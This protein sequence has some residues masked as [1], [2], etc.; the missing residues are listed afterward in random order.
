MSNVFE[1]EDAVDPAVAEAEALRREGR[2]LKGYERV[3]HRTAA[4]PR[5]TFTIRVGAHELTEIADA[6]RRQGQPVGDF[7]RGAA[8]ERARSGRPSERR[9]L[10]KPV[11]DALDEL[12]RR[13]AE[14]E[15]ETSRRRRRPAKAG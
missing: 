2:Q 7:I 15:R 5:N 12:V 9:W 13:V 11:A 3:E 1:D 14:Q 8:L 10:E 4:P 6:A